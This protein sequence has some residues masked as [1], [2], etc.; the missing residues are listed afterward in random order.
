[1]N[2]DIHLICELHVPEELY[3]TACGLCDAVSQFFLY[4]KYYFTFNLRNVRTAA[5]Q[6]VGMNINLREIYLKLISTD[7]CELSWKLSSTLTSENEICYTKN[8]EKYADSKTN[9]I[10]CLNLANKSSGRRAG[11]S[12]LYVTVFIV[13]RE[14]RSKHNFRITCFH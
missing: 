4:P 3:R 8:E 14:R 10:F 1:M 13:R 9:F 6:N 11:V 5:K 2:T 7:F 12:Y